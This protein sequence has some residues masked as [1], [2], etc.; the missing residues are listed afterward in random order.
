MNQP[1]TTRNRLLRTA[2]YLATAGALLAAMPLLDLACSDHPAHVAPPQA[3]GSLSTGTATASVEVNTTTGSYAI[4]NAV[5][6]W[7]FAGMIGHAITDSGKKLETDRIGPCN[8]I[9]LNW[10]DDGPVTGEIRCY[11][12]QPIVRF[13]LICQTARLRPPA[14]FPAVKPPVELH[15]FGYTDGVFAPPSFKGGHG[16]S[17]WLLFDNNTRAAIFSPASNFMTADLKKQTD[18]TLASGMLP[19]LRGIPAGYTQDSLL[20]FADSIHQ[21]WD[22]WGHAMTDLTG[23]TRPTNTADLPLERFGYWT[24]NGAAYYY[25]YDK[26]LGYEGTMLAVRDAFTKAKIPLGYL[27]LDSWWYIKSTTGYDGKRGGEFKNSKMPRGTWNCYGGLTEYVAHPFVFPD[28]LAG[29]HDKLGLPLVTHNRW[30]DVDSPY[31]EKYRISG[32]A[33]VDPRWWN[34]ICDYLKQAGVI[35][36]EQDWLNEI[37]AFSPEFSTTT[38]AG[39]AF[40]DNMARATR[41]HGMSM[42]YCMT[43]PRYVMQGSKYA[44]LTTVRV[45]DDR[46][47]RNDWNPAIYESAFTTALGEW[48]WVDNYRSRELPNNI[49]ATLSAG[50]VGVSDDIDRIDAANIFQSIR[51]DGVIV[52]PDTALV[53]LD[54]VYLSDA[55][56]HRSPMIAAA[57]TDH[58]PIRTAYV[59]AYPRSAGQMKIEFAPQEM[60]I[61]SDAWVYDTRTGKAQRIPAGGTFTGSFINPAYKQAWGSFVV[62][63]VTPSGIAMLGDKGKIASNGRQRISSLE[64]TS[65]GLNASVLFASGEKS[66][67]LHGF[68]PETVRVISADGGTATLTHDP[69]TQ[70]FSLKVAPATDGACVVVKLASAAEPATSR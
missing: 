22:R 44:N 29:F 45:S 2:A 67:E 5:T 19:T 59:F 4:T 15:P 58:G 34:D 63:P 66:I 20:V 24:D 64:Q 36:Y 57:Y 12:D 48:P 30:I 21:A 46:F 25:T 31:R 18:G 7:R 27:Q 47:G 23:K 68:C 39:D 61:N 9:E 1:Q 13:R 11:L 49:I 55:T 35:T 38:W 53:P 51:A 41:E 33:A 56:N 37:Y 70:A 69:A 54:R 26:K 42:Q 16:S 52:K 3:A 28:G 32:V 60:G 17:P 50:M 14:A 40:T 65:D 62:A 6:G 10:D 8:V 43:T